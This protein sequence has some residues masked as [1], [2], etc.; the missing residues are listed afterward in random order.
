MRRMNWG[1]VVL[2][3][4]AVT[5]VVGVSQAT[6]ADCTPCEHG[7]PKDLVVSG[8]PDSG[9]DGTY[10]FDEYDDN[11]YPMYDGPGSWHIK[12]FD[13]MSPPAWSIMDS[14]VLKY[15]AEDSSCFP[16]ASGWIVRYGG[17]PTS[18]SI[19]GGGCPPP[20]PVGVTIDPTSGLTTTEAGGTGTFTVVLDGRPSASVTLNLASS[21]TAEGTVSPATLTFA[22]YNWDTPQTVTIT[23]VDDGVDD[24]DIAYTIVTDPV[25]SADANYDGLDPDDVSVTNTDDDEVGINVSPTS[26]LTTTEAGGTDTFSVVLGSQPSDTVTIGASSNNTDE[27]TVAPGTLTFGVGNWNEPQTVT[28]TGVDDDFDDGDVAYTIVT[29]DPTSNDAAYNALGAD[30]VD[31][32]SATNTDDDTRGVV[33]SPT[34]GLTTTEAGGTAT[35]TVVLDSEPILNGPARPAWSGVSIEISSSNAAEGTVEPD[36]LVFTAENW[37]T[38][39]TVTVTGVDDDY[40]DGDVGYTIVTG[41]AVGGDYDG[42]D[43]NDVL[44]TNVDDDTRGISV[45]PTLGLA[46]TEAG[47]AATFTVVLDSKPILHACAGSGDKAWG[48]VT[49]DLSSSNPAEGAVEP[50]ALVFT[51]ENWDTPQ[52]VTVTG[53]DDFDFDGDVGYTIVT[54]PAIGGDYDGLNASDVAVTNRDDEFAVIVPTGEAGPEA[55]LDTLL[56]LGEGE[57]PAMAGDK[58]LVASYVVGDLITGSC[59]TLGLG[60]NP[61]SDGYIHLYLYSVDVT[62]E[63]ETLVLIAHWAAEFNWDTLEF[64]FS[65][66]TSGLTPGY[67]DLRLS[68]HNGLSETFRVEVTPAV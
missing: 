43:V 18:I 59:Q 52:T 1:L 49:I 13:Y 24:G 2:L 15:N 25:T 30:D 65:Y 21:N 19:T 31:D 47:G 62:M 27:G 66:D 33:V 5:T 63:P 39:Q 46:T 26:G 35:F 45:T 51:E 16:P 40:D 48:G 17:D 38:P 3:L 50:T 54:E 57:T 56:P 6:L 4:A 23:G 9:A 53:V 32:V 42:L 58:P 34:S 22:T 11:N 44:V 12:F 7:D 64:E 67:Y 28:I 8:A 37:D 60:G 10:E 14:H 20:P 68:F 55:F 41:K 36:A 61:T 29:G